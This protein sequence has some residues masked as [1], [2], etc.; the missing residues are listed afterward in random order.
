MTKKRLFDLIAD[1]IFEMEGESKAKR[2]LHADVGQI[3]L[4][5]S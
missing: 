2:A 1:N 3:P 4:L 5:H